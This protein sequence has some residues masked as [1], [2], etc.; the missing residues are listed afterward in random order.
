M[1]S[2]WA[3]EEA[4]ESIKITADGRVLFSDG[5]ISTQTQPYKIDLDLTGVKDLKIEMYAAEGL[6]GIDVMLGDPVLLKAN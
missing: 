4:A 1:G 2:R 6:W 5:S 3:Y